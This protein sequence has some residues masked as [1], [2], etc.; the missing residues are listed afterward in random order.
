MSASTV[1][2][3]VSRRN[4]LKTTA[5][6]AAGL[7]IGFHWAPGAFAQEQSQEKPKVNPFQ[8]WLHINKEGDV[9]LIV[10]KSEMGQ[11]VLPSLAMILADELEV[12]WKKVHVEH[13]ETKPDIYDLGTGGSGSVLGSYLALRQA[14][15]A[16][17]QMLITAAAQTW[18]VS[19]LSC[20]ASE[21]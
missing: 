15:A 6:S 3:K 8:A 12:D 11:G 4:F 10:P 19:P 18:G 17:R 5:A 2:T 20:H 1:E 14:G 7:A 13:A 16:A 21:R 9:T